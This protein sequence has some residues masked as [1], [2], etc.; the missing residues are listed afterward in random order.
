M[1][2]HHQNLAGSSSDQSCS[3]SSGSDSDSDSSSS[4]SGNRIPS[5]YRSILPPNKSDDVS[6][7]NAEELESEDLWLIRLP[8]GL[9]PKHLSNLKLKLPSDEVASSSDQPIRVG[10]IQV[11]KLYYDA[12]AEPL[13]R[14]DRKAVEEKRVASELGE[15][16]QLLPLIPTQSRDPENTRI[17]LAQKPISRV[18]FFRRRP[19]IELPSPTTAETSL[20][21]RKT[22]QIL[23]T[24][25][26]PQ[27]A[28]LECRN[29]PYGA[30]SAG[31]L[32]PTHSSSSDDD[33]KR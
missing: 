9:K 31:Y 32:Y 22:Q 21:S 3:S 2:Q 6:A 30:E 13:T 10:E 25:K 11:G 14:N 8:T 4:A 24:L 16:S 12:Y 7:L 29:V 28:G 27:P 1:S 33:N 5:D 19:P 26:R 15:A 23:P 20:I 18:V 17:V